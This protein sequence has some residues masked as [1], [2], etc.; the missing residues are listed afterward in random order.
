MRPTDGSHV[1]RNGGAKN[2]WQS[3]TGHRSA[4]DYPHARARWPAPSSDKCSFAQRTIRE[5]E[6]TSH[7][8]CGRRAPSCSCSGRAR[9]VGSP[10]SRGPRP[11]LVVRGRV[12]QA[13]LGRLSDPHGGCL[14]VRSKWTTGLP[15]LAV[16]GSRV[17]AAEHPK[18]G[19]AGRCAPHDRCL[20]S[21]I[22]SPS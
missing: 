21:R 11:H 5:S 13:E 19:K 16:A 8:L 20:R 17:A 12:T 18:Q 6:R 22:T 2:V 1:R 15:K 7:R 4:L 10:P 9:R 14:T 3:P